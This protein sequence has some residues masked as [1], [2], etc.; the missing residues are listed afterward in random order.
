MY[1][2]QF[3]FSYIFKMYL[4]ENIWLSSR[5]VWILKFK[6]RDSADKVH[7]CLSRE[8]LTIQITS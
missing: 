4:F 8:K 5:F 2:F 7:A 1:Q 3:Y 6:T